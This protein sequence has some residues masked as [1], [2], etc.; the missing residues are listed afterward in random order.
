MSEFFFGTGRGHLPQRAARIARAHGAT[1]VNTWEPGCQ[2]GHGCH[3]ECPECRRHWFAGPNR[4]EPFDSA[5]ARAVM[6]EIGG[7]Q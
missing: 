4:G 6:A 3:D 1:L 2:C 7:A 5:L